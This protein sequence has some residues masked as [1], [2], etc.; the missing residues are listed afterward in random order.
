[1]SWEALWIVENHSEKCGSETM[2]KLWEQSSRVSG[3]EQPR[4]LSLVS[5]GVIHG[6]HVVDVA[7]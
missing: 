4:Q 6:M 1:M 2:L 7:I 3:E 5:L